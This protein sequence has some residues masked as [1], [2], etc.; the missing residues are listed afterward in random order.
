MPATVFRFMNTHFVW[1][2]FQELRTPRGLLWACGTLGIFEPPTAFSTP[3]QGG[4]SSKKQPAWH[5]GVDPENFFCFKSP[6]FHENYQ[7]LSKMVEIRGFLG[8]YLKTLAKDSNQVAMSTLPHL[9][10]KRS[11]AETLPGNTSIPPKKEIYVG[12]GMTKMQREWY[13]NVLAKDCPLPSKEICPWP[14][15]LVA[16]CSKHNV[17]GLSLKKWSLGSRIIFGSRNILYSYMTLAGFLGQHTT[18]NMQHTT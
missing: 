13:T 3:P 8:F 15:L 7:N 17:C 16:K 1:L 6:K 18:C 11:T 9:A 10:A 12:C 14:I 4:G 2:L 5:S